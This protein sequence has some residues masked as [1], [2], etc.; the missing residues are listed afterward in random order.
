[1]IQSRDINGTTET[2]FL[3]KLRDNSTRQ[4]KQTCKHFGH[5]EE[6]NTQS[7]SSLL[8]QRK[9]AKLTVTV[10][11]TCR[12]ESS[13]FSPSFSPSW[14]CCFADAK[15]NPPSH[16]MLFVPFF[17]QATP[18]LCGLEGKAFMEEKGKIM[19]TTTS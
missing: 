11:H 18:I 6:E 2:A 16:L 13:K 10:C 12:A 8:E 9:E 7:R 5:Q 1:M 17:L 15:R 19:C 14:I 4:K 3:H